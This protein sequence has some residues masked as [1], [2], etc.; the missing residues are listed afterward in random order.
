MPTELTPLVQAALI[1][2]ALPIL[3]TLRL[4]TPSVRQV[5]DA[6]GVTRSRAYAL[7]G[8][9]ERSLPELHR[10]VGR[11]RAAPPEPTNEDAFSVV[12]KVR[13]FLLANPGAALSG[14]RGFY[15]ARFRLFVLDLVG[16]GGEASHMTSEQA[17]VAI[18]IPEDTLLSWLRQPRPAPANSVTVVGAPVPSGVVAQVI[19]LYKRWNGPLDRFR[20]V[21]LEHHRIDISWHLLRSL[22]ALTGHRKL[23][24]RRGLRNPETIRGALERFFPGAQ[25]MA[26]GKQL[27]V[28]LDGV[29]YTLN[30]ELAVDADTG[31]HVGFQV[32]PTEDGQA[33]IDAVDVAIETL[34]EPPIAVLADNKPSNHSEDVQEAMEDRDILLM[35]STVGRPENKSTCE[36]GF[37]LF[38]QSMP[39]IVLDGA[40]PQSLVRSVVVYVLWAYCAGRNQ[41]PQSR[42]D[43]KSAVPLFEEA[44]ITEED[45]HEAEQ[46][47]LE[48]KKRIE[49]RRK[50]D[51]RR[52]D[53]VI[54]AIVDR[55][56]ADLGLSDPEGRFT[57][58]LVRLGLAP[59]LEALAIF[60][61]KRDAG[62]IP[63]DFPERY[64]VGIASN[65]AQRNEDLDVYY[66]LLRLRTEA[67]DGLLRPL[68]GQC[69]RLGPADSIDFVRAVIDKLAAATATVDRRFWMARLIEAFE[70]FDSDE[71]LLHG[72]WLARRVACL[73]A[74]PRHNRDFLIA[75][76]AEATAA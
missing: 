75:K 62:K 56:F 60:K 58:D 72:P 37:G 66:E 7:A 52:E 42:R 28:E 11:P 45:R 19:E 50:D 12:C 76:L 67:H 38:A 40:T 53:L 51:R 43:G 48:I 54:R 36:G 59:A 16:P 33:L 49:D 2:V 1:I 35:P 64:L 73:F 65:V 68:I 34:G 30:W 63:T 71:R 13:D 5:I 29:L 32:S 22:L 39:D 31:A 47:L 46:R 24:K 74:L 26:D 15:S 23:E 14:K 10:P 8:A 27:Q 20:E 55:E 4:P 70:T 61:A 25:L 17:A 44:V 18:G 3:K 9:V 21:L 69:Q 57:A 41:A 6:L